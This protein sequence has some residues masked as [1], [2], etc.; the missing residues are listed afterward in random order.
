MLSASSCSVRPRVLASSSRNRSSG[1]AGFCRS[2]PIEAGEPLRHAEQA[3]RGFHVLRTEG[4]P[5]GGV[6]DGVAVGI[7]TVCASSAG[8]CANARPSSPAVA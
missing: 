2:L 8:I 7:D 5:G 3:Q 6:I 4:F 1:A